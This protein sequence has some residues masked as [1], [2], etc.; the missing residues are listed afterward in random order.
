MDDQALRAAY[1]R[2]MDTR[3]ASRA[4]CP[5]PEAVRDLAERRQHDDSSTAAFD[6]VMACR[7]CLAEY[8]LL[9]ALHHAQPAARP[10]HVGRRL[11]P[12]AL[13]ATALLAV[14][15]TAV[16]RRPAETLRGPGDSVQL[17]TTPVAWG[18]A[19]TLHLT[20][21]PTPGAEAY[22]VDVTTGVGTPVFTVTTGDTTVALARATV[23][24]GTTSIDVM[25]AAI[26]PGTTERRAPLL[27]VAIVP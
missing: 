21:H 19:D 22:R 27:R 20:W 1:A 10:A 24:A 16:L 8:E 17:V 14:T 13:A 6:H 26:G 25:I 23:P 11:V 12:L 2:A 3:G 18:S 4:T 15:I 5:P 7:E 9:R